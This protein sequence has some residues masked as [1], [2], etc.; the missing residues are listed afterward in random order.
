M[1]KLVLAFIIFCFLP[2]QIIQGA[3]SSQAPEGFKRRG[4]YLHGCWAFNYPF[5]VRTW[6]RS[7]YDHMFQ[8]LKAM[9]FDTVM[10]WPVLEAVPPPLSAEDA[11]AV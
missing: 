7:D 9:N 3:E 2:I 10:L 4:F 8:F 6:T 1:R 11:E 5:A